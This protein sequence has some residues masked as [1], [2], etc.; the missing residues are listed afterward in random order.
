M[1]LNL[2]Q[3]IVR[4]LCVKRVAFSLVVWWQTPKKYLINVETWPCDFSLIDSVHLSIFFHSSYLYGHYHHNYL[5]CD[6]LYLRRNNLVWYSI[7]LYIFSVHVSRRRILFS[8]HT[9]VILVFRYVVL[10]FSME[11]KTP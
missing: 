11:K 3:S 4:I 7:M 10:L 9:F 5:C 2:S 8:G 6:M 1:G